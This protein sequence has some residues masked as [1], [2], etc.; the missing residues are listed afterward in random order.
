M[1]SKLKVTFLGTGSALGVPQMGCYCSICSSKLKANKRQRTGYLIEKNGKSFIL[2]PGP[3]IRAQ[4]LEHPIKRLEGVLISHAHHD[5]IGGYDDLRVFSL[6]QEELVPT[7]LH[8]KTEPG[9]LSR[10][11]Y[12]LKPGY[13]FF[14]LEL[15]ND[16]QGSGEFE[17][18]HYRY[19][20]Y[21]Q[22]G[23]NVTGFI[24]DDIAFVSDIQTVDEK[25]AQHLQGIE[26]LIVSCVLKPYGSYKSHLNLDE[27]YELK[28]RTGA[29]NVIITHMGHDID[30]TTLSAK[31]ENDVILSYDGFI[32]EA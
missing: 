12:L 32:Y 15:L 8:A 5:H 30:Y 24:I 10:C 28:I 20:T 29:K 21:I 4:L 2:D 7:L 25:L 31:L 9:L 1:K 11:H 14:S 13:T 16:D 3:D 22:N 27:I 26:T 19:I 23:M 17:G 18:L 6:I